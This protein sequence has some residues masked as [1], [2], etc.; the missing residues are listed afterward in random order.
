MISPD[1]F[2]WGKSFYLCWQFALLLCFS[3][4]FIQNPILRLPTPGCTV[5][6]VAQ[7]RRK[8]FQNQGVAPCTAA[9]EEGEGKQY[10]SSIPSI[11][12]MGASLWHCRPRCPRWHSVLL[13][14]NHSSGPGTVQYRTSRWFTE[15]TS[16]DSL[17]RRR[18]A[19]GCEGI[20]EERHKRV[21]KWVRAGDQEKKAVI[22]V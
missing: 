14:E 1:C 3:S 13:M 6:W 16:S 11:W 5:H 17:R 7:R 19:C 8:R 18:R 22:S 20:M 4:W 10:K 12:K 15:E 2:H 9:A 21:G